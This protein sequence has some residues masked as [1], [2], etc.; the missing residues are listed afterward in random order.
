MA[1]SKHAPPFPV[2]D[3]KQR[4]DPEGPDRKGGGK[5]LIFRQ[6]QHPVQH[7]EKGDEEKEACRSDKKEWFCSGKAEE[8]RGEGECDEKRQERERKLVVQVGPDGVY[9]GALLKALQKKRL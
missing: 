7:G 3:Q 5:H 8:M 9:I 2:H 4:R 6:D 1:A